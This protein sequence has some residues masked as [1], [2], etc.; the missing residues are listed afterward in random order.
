MN[1]QICIRNVI[2]FNGFHLLYFPYQDGGGKDAQF[3]LDYRVDSEMQEQHILLFLHIHF[4]K[5]DL[6]SQQCV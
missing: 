5:N 6:L 2:K 1:I 4:Q 3:Y